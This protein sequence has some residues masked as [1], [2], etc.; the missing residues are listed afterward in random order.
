MQKVNVKRC[1]ASA[2]SCRKDDLLVFVV[3]GVIGAVLNKA[4]VDYTLP[5][6]CTPVTLFPTSPIFSECGGD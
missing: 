2:V 4:I 3:N 6:L 1:F 5:M